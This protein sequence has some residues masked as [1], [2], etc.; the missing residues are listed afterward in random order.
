MISHEI[1]VILEIWL[2]HGIHRCRINSSRIMFAIADNPG[3]TFQSS[4]VGGKEPSFVVFAFVFI[5]MCG[6]P[7]PYPVE[8]AIELTIKNKCQLFFLN[9]GNT[10][11]QRVYEGRRP[12]FTVSLVKVFVA[13]SLS[14]CVR[15]WALF[16]F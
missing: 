10:S 13:H 8:W 6:A 12:S 14:R 1:E 4:Q 9:E 16:V 5:R 3:S 7:H 11:K 2:L 15:P